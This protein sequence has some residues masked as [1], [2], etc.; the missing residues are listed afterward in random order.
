MKIKM[1]VP[2]SNI[3]KTDSNYVAGLYVA[4]PQK[5]DNVERPP[6]TVDLS[7]KVVKSKTIK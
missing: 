7:K 3:I 1:P 6:V 4:M 2:D 5:R